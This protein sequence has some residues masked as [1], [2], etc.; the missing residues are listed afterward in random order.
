MGIF[1]SL[2]QIRMPLIFSR[3]DSGHRGPE[4]EV[5]QENQ[6]GERANVDLRRGRLL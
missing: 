5:L 6:W 4:Q 3:R 1:S 2:A